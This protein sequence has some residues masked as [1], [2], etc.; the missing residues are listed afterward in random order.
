[1]INT[2]EN[3]R[4]AITN[5]N[6][7]RVDHMRYGTCVTPTGKVKR[8]K[9]PLYVKEELR[10]EYMRN[11][12]KKSERKAEFKRRKESTN[13]SIRTKVRRMLKE[14]KGSNTPK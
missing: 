11:K 12:K 13:A 2:E 1:M 8:Q 7:K 3:A 5:N 10:R 4:N 14:K 6:T 9:I